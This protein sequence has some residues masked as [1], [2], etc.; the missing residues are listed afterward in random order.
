MLS[1]INRF[2]QWRGS[3]S[4]AEQHILNSAL[5]ISDYVNSVDNL[6]VIKANAKTKYNDFNQ[7][8]VRPWGVAAFVKLF[9]DEAIDQLPE[10][11][12]KEIALL[13]HSSEVIS[14]LYGNWRDNTAGNILALIGD[15]EKLLVLDR[16][17]FADKNQYKTFLLSSCMLFHII[18]LAI[19][20]IESDWKVR[21][22]V[23][24]FLDLG[25]IK[26]KLEFF[27][28]KIEERMEQLQQPKQITDKAAPDPLKPAK[29][30]LSKRYL[31]VLG[32]DSGFT[33]K[34]QK[35]TKSSVLKTQA[36]G[37][38]R[39]Q[40]LDKK[41]RRRSILDSL[42]VLEAD[43]EKVASG[44]FNLIDQRNKKGRLEAKIEEV[45]KLLLFAEEND[46]KIVRRKYFLDFIEEHAELFQTLL[47][48]TE[49]IRK[50][51]LLEKIKQ[52]KSIGESSDLTL[53]VMHGVSWVA[54]PIAVV[55]RTATPQSLQNMI[56]TT[57]P[58]T[59]DG[60]CKAELKEM[61]NACLLDL[62]SKLKKKEHQIAAINNRFFNQDEALK[63]LIE[64]ESSERLTVLQKSNDVMKEAVKASSKLLATVKENSLFLHD[65]QTKSQILSDF[66]RLHDGFFVKVCNFLAQ[67]FA[68][69]KTK[70]AKMIDDAAVLKIKVDGL[71][72]EY[73]R[74]VVQGVRQIENIPYLDER[75]KTHIK[76]QFYAE[77]YEISQEKQ[78]HNHPNKRTVR[79]LMNNLSRLFASRPQ[80]TKE[81]I[82]EIGDD[83]EKPVLACF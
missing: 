50:E 18:Q 33:E 23:A 73:Q 12:E 60:A 25:Q 64:N 20:E 78:N 32:V 51:Q 37:A 9:I 22:V 2:K 44:I 42:A 69:F 31:K 17:P 21:I 43:I 83:E 77:E 27:L 65:L 81:Q 53:G 58:S 80:S 19:A 5:I 71:V 38:P 66:I 48:N 45:H 14:T 49:A 6:A 47:E 63:L 70:T 36:P 62:K 10:T 35:T 41:P 55:Y 56:A 7:Y 59:L 61:A 40:R 54:S 15:I 8:K 13:T 28:L 39:L 57:L 67:Y 72:G 46:Q 16:V 76:S 68:C 4:D 34:P 24:A 79:L 30:L 26:P 74:A 52:L 82:N 29:D 3:K 11:A 1:K 75:I